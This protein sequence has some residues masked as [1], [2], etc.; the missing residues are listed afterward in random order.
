MKIVNRIVVTI[1]AFSVFPLMFFLNLVRAVLSIS[2]DS[3]LYSILSKIASDTVNSRMEI[4]LSVKEAM[5]YFRDGKFSFA[6]MDFSTKK[7]PAEMLV[8]KN[9]LIAAAVLLVVALLIALVIAGC[10]IFTEAYRTE[11]CLGAGGIVC[12]FAAVRCFAKFAAPFVSGK[13]D[14]GELLAK[15]LLGDDSGIVGTLGTAF[16]KKSISV[17]VLQLSNA[18]MLLAIAFFAIILWTLAFYLTLPEKDKPKKIK[19]PAGAKR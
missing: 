16:L 3:S 4:T 2:E 11:M 5:G 15:N 6:G 19:K 18:V 13:I 14:I 9:W 7:I 10:A 8:T 1:M 17:D 12:A